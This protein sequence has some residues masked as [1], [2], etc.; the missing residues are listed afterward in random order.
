MANLPNSTSKLSLCILF[1]Y[2]VI[3][4]TGSDSAIIKRT[5][6]LDRSHIVWMIPTDL[7]ATGRRTASEDIFYQI[8]SITNINS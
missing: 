6:L 8:D 3:R 1:L 4:G 5:G 7:I 2:R